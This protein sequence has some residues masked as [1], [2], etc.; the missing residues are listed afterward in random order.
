[1]V[2]NGGESQYAHYDGDCTEAKR[3]GESRNLSTREDQFRQ[4]GEGKNQY[5]DIGNHVHDPVDFEKVCVP[6]V[7]LGSC[8]K[9]FGDFGPAPEHGQK[10]RCYRKGD[11]YGSADVEGNAQLGESF[12]YDGVEEG[13]DAEFKDVEGAVVEQD[14][15]EGEFEQ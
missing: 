2:H 1:M 10:G 5:E 11:G 6:E 13:E 3:D 9:V 12:R 4:Q 8:Y 7:A 15:C 14:R